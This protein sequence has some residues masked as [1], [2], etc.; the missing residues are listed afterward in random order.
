MIA[1]PRTGREL[2]HPPAAAVPSL[3]HRERAGFLDDC[4]PLSG[5]KGESLIGVKVLT[6]SLIGRSGG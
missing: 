1:R 3:S 5:P 4:G 6:E 2:S